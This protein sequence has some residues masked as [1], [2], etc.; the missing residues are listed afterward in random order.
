MCN[1][2][3]YELTTK[4]SIVDRLLINSYILP[5]PLLLIPVYLKFDF[6]IYHLIKSNDLLAFMFSVACSSSQSKNGFKRWNSMQCF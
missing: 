3:Y 1:G 5:W 6:L 2:Y 4:Y